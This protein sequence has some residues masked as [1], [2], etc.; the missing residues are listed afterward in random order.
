MQVNFSRRNV[1]LN[2]YECLGLLYVGHS[3]TL[4]I[5]NI[6]LNLFFGLCSLL[7]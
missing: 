7:D 2:I 3:K 4:Q 6:K 5:K 1:R